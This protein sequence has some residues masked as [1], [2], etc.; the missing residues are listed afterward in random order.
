[1]CPA[2]VI[3]YTRNSTAKEFFPRVFAGHI[4]C[5]FTRSWTPSQKSPMVLQQM[6]GTT[7]AVVR[8][9]NTSATVFEKVENLVK[10]PSQ[11]S[12][13]WY[14]YTSVLYNFV[15]EISPH[16]KWTKNKKRN[17]KIDKQGY[18]SMSTISRRSLK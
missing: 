9:C 7:D 17:K 5:I 10:Y 11:I 16:T 6:C 2:L 3:R 1:M 18:I 14:K 15:K 13:V 8:L 12:R 4:T